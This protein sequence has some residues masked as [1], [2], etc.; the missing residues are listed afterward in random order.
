MSFT[1][2]RICYKISGGI[3]IIPLHTSVSDICISTNYVLCIKG[4]YEVLYAKTTT[5]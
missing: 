5:A 1:D 2:T 3:H 4:Q